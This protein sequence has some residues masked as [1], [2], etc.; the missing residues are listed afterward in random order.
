MYNNA[1]NVTNFQNLISYAN[2]ASDGLF[3]VC[4]LFSLF[5]V[6]GI[7]FA[8]KNT[9]EGLLLSSFITSL[10]AILMSAAG[11]INNMILGGTL[12]IFFIFVMVLFLGKKN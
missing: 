8:R 6:L 3:A 11:L 1:T 7:T 4:M 5:I 9:E 12:G 2:V 10:V